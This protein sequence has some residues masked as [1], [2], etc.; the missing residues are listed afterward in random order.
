MIAHP[1]SGDGLVVLTNSDRGS[2]LYPDVIDLIGRR[3]G[4]PGF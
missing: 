1:S 3:E 2:D 4:W